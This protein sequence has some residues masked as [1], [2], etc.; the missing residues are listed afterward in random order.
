MSTVVVAEPP[1]PSLASTVSMY[2]GS[3]SW[4]RAPDTVIAPVLVATANLPAPLPPMI[5]YSTV[6]PSSGSVAVTA[7]TEVP[8]AAVS[9]T[10]NA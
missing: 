7:P 4:S 5:P 2:D 6:S 3:V 1:L 8:V 10:E 9:A